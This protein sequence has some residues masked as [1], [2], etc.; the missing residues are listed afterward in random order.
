MSSL[1]LLSPSSVK[2]HVLNIPTKG[3]FPNS[4]PSGLPAV[5]Y[6]PFENST[7]APGTQ[8][9]GALA[10]TESQ[11]SPLDPSDIEQLVSKNGFEPSWRYGMFPFDHYHSNVHELLIPYKGTAT[12]M[13]GTTTT[14]SV[15]PGDALLLPASMA[16]RC[17]ESSSD[18]SMVGSYPRGASQ[19]DTCRGGEQGAEERIRSL[20]KTGVEVDPVYGQKGETPV[21]DAWGL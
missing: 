8:A 11:A 12:L 2:S 17:V 14:L 16:H 21:G 18:Y 4:S 20:G 5:F 6:H 3:A 19:W 7:D 15:Q 1:R 13:L 10:T 9:D